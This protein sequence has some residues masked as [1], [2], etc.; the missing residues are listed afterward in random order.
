MDVLIARGLGVLGV[1]VECR[2]LVVLRVG[3][4]GAPNCTTGLA[5]PADQHLAPTPRPPAMDTGGLVRLWTVDC[6]L[7][8]CCRGAA[9]LRARCGDLDGD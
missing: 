5:S 7:S 9:E 2:G 3:G 4:G 6:G 8:V 1:G